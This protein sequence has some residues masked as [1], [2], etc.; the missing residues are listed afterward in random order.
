MR[1]FALVMKEELESRNLARV[2]IDQRLL[3]LD[4]SFVPEIFDAVHQMGTT[5]IGR[6]ADD[7]FVDAD[8]KVFGTRNLF[9]AGACTFPTT[10]FANPT[11]TAISLALRLGDKLAGSA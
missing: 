11:F 9:I 2:K 3:D 5:R 7:G 8:L 6:N 10:G 4:P 1:A